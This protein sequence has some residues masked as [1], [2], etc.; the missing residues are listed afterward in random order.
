MCLEHPP[1]G[2]PAAIADYDALTDYLADLDRPLLGPPGVF[3]SYSNEGYGLL[4]A[5]V[6]AVSGETYSRYV[7]GRILGPCG[8]TSSTFRNPGAN[9]L[10]RATELYDVRQLAGGTEEV[11]PSPGWSDAPAM[12]GAGWLRATVPDLLR[13]LQMYLGR[14]EIGGER[15]LS[16]QGI[17]KML[18]PRVETSPGRFYAY[19]FAVVRDFYGHDMV[20][21]SG[22]LKGVGADVGFI[23]ELGLAGAALANLMGPAARQTVQGGLAFAMGLP[24][25]PLHRD[26]PPFAPQPARFRDYLGAYPSG[27]GE[28]YRTTLREGEL[29]LDDGTTALAL[30]PVGEDAFVMRER[31]DE[32]YVRFHRHGGQ[33]RAVSVGT[34]MI[35]RVEPT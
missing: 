12:I 29:W 31:D 9:G 6:E 13:Y 15:L 5:V 35:L 25:R 18:R 32:T 4:G 22:G 34:R 7:E 24:A 16:A 33:V 30:Q 3:F 17:A 10:A 27:E 23:P 8:M 20:G 14:G 11:Y 21:H 28:T 2:S 19:G 1:D 26:Y